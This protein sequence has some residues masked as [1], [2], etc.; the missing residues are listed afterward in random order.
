MG[1]DLAE[2]PPTDS[3]FLIKFTITN[4][5][6]VTVQNPL[7]WRNRADRLTVGYD[8]LMENKLTV[9]FDPTHHFW[10]K[11][12]ESVPGG[13][14]ILKA[15]DEALRLSLKN[16]ELDWTT[17]EQLGV[18]VIWKRDKPKEDIQLIG[19]YQGGPIYT[20][21]PVH[22][23]FGKSDDA[24]KRAF[25]LLMAFTTE[26]A[27]S[28]GY[29]T[30]IDAAHPNRTPTASFAPKNARPANLK[31]IGPK[32]FLY[33][34]DYIRKFMSDVEESEVSDLA[35][36]KAAYLRSEFIEALDRETPAD[37]VQISKAIKVQIDRDLPDTVLE[38]L[39]EVRRQKVRQRSALIAIAFKK[40][41]E[42]EGPQGNRVKARVTN[43]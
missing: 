35:Q 25:P 12:S 39:A 31:S 6:K 8:R 14:A 34:P 17:D 4:A 38:G 1:T 19:F 20:D 26:L 3:D 16:V 10:K 11:L 23:V 30:R 21:T 15:L 18:Q 33:W 13:M 37:S 32:E 36:R 29:P 28:L 2:N 22:T 24:Q 40:K 27:T 5:R 43:R 7:R 9:S 42:K 41:R